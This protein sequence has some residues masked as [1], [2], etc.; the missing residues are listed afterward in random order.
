M[1]DVDHVI[2]KC[3]KEEI[4]FQS[5]SP[6]C[7]PCTYKP[8]D[9]L[10]DGTLVSGIAAKHNVSGAQVSLRFIV[11]QAL[12]GKYIGAVIPKSDNPKHLASN[13]DVFGF[14]LTASE[15]SA[16]S[17]ASKPAGEAGDCSVTTV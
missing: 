5:F 12:E 3:A 7:G 9:S 1:G 13:I 16:L 17:G 15:M 10:I 6:L 11:Q 4:F 14:N 8:E 2:S